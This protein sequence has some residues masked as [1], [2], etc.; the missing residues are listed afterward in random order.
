MHATITSVPSGRPWPRSLRVMVRPPME[1]RLSP[2]TAAAS[3]EG[4]RDERASAKR[5]LIVD[6]NVDNAASLAT[7]LTFDGHDVHVAHEGDQAL[8][9][10]S[11]V[12]PEVAL[13]DIGLPGM[14]GYDLAT[15]IRQLPDV[16]APLLIALSGYASSRSNDASS[17]TAFDHYLVK[18]LD[19]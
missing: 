15:R 3:F 9:L 1:A 11:K 8:K 16:A 4:K 5:V 14:N 7:L 17:A 2:D 18:P 6:D 13:L 10:A 12:R 19:F